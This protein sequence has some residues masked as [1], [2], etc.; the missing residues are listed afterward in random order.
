MLVGLT[1]L[2]VIIFYAHKSDAYVRINVGLGLFVVALLVVPVLNAV[3]I[4]DQVGL[5][6]GFYATVGAIGLS[7]I[8]DA[9]VQGVLIGAVG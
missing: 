9:L 7:D 6:A 5:Y 3:Y 4:K 2:L 8:A 1:C